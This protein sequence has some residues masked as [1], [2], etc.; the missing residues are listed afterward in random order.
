MKFKGYYAVIEN[1]TQFSAAMAVYVCNESDDQL[2]V[3]RVA[4]EMG[5]FK[6]SYLVETKK[7]W[8]NKDRLIG[9]YISARDA[10]MAA[11][12]VAS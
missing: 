12:E 1:R 9:K 3:R 7:A 10:S 4:M 11:S 5:K 6:P 8:V 2:K